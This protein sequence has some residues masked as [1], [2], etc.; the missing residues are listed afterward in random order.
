MKLE[1]KRFHHGEED[2]LGL[3]FVDGVFYCFVLEDEFRA[4]KL[5]AETRI[6]EG[7]YPLGLRY[8]PSHSMRYGHDMIFLRAVP[9][10]SPNSILI[11]KGNTEKDTAGCLLV[12]M[13]VQFNPDWTSMILRSGEAYDR[14]Y[15]IVAKG[16]TEE[17]AHIIVSR[18]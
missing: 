10:F 1:L 15:P 12:G 16:I 3:L 5:Y 11:H 7:A 6:P 13:T 17:G 14:L 2:T 9:G 8:S 18:M 4:P